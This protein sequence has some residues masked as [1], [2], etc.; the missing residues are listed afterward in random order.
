MKEVKDFIEKLK[1]ERNRL[2]EKLRFVGEHKF[3]HEQKALNEKITVIN[4]IMYELE[5]VANGRTKGID[6]NFLFL[7]E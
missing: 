4:H 1:D 3:K 5:S 7:S 2:N 6:A